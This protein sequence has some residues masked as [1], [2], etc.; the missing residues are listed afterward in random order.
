MS[1]SITVNLPTLAGKNKEIATGAISSSLIAGG[2]IKLP[3]FP[4]DASQHKHDGHLRR[5]R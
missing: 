1:T 4:D 5:R 2:L 3:E